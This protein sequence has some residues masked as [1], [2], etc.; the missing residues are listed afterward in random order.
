MLPSAD[1]EGTVGDSE[2][3]VGLA[4]VGDADLV[5]A[6]SLDPEEHAVRAA[7]SMNMRESRRIVI[8]PHRVVRARAWLGI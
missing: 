6:T 3:V 5:E 4:A 2:A 1:V 8:R 7:M